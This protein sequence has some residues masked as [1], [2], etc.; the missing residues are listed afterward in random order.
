MQRGWWVN[1]EAQT[2]FLM[3]GSFICG[4]FMNDFLQLILGTRE[5]TDDEYH[6]MEL[7][8]SEASRKEIERRVELL[9]KKE[10]N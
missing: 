8:K 7:E 5:L 9:Q 6:K 4:Y 1:L 2:I 3:L 10:P